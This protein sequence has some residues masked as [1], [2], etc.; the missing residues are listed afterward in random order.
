MKKTLAAVGQ[1]CSTASL[2]ENAASAGRL[3]RQ[4][5]ESGAKVLF[6]P[7]ASDY[8]GGSAE[9]TVSLAQNVDESEFMKG[10]R[11][12]LLD[13]PEDRRPEISVGVHEP[14]ENE[15]RVKNTLLWLDRR[16]QIKHRYQKIH[17]FDVDIANGPILKE[18]RSVQP[19]TEVIK[20]FDTPVGKLGPAIC[21]DIRFPEHA[22]R[23]RSLGAQI[24]Q[25][26]SA[27]TV[28][29]GQAHWEV[30]ARARAIDTQCYVVMPA[31]V[32]MHSAD[33]KRHSYG[34]SLVVDPWG[35]VVAQAPDITSDPC[36][37]LAEIDLD[38]L[39]KGKFSPMF[40]KLY[41]NN[42]STCKHAAMG[43]T[44]TRYLWI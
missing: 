8:I 16:G 41:T 19:G 28:R 23:L 42:S 25:F 44:K 43:P 33:G 35:T 36:I 38:S 14:V 9:E 37:I 11:A 17:L 3:I 29:T 40:F 32:G 7:E 26:P 30:L 31:Q 13:I 20:P 10:I 12:H 18:S 6:L 21:Y 39:Q 34:H 22:L 15:D 5:S 4:A 1:L 27:F 24:I 2:R